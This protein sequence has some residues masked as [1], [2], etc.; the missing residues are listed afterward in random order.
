M[1]AGTAYRL[2]FAAGTLL[3]LLLLQRVLARLLGGR[4]AERNPAGTMFEAGETLGLFLIAG[5][6]VATCVHEESAGE[7]AARVLAFG[8]SGALLLALAGRLGARVLVRARLEAE[9]AAG[10]TAAGI[11]AGAHAAATG[12]IVAGCVVGDDLGS[13]GISLLFFLVA[14]ATLHGLVLL[15]RW[16]T[17]YDDAEEILDRNTAAAFS[18]AGVTVALGLIVSHAV[19]GEFLGLWASLRAYG[20]ALLAGVFLWPV[21]Q[22]VVQGLILGGR[23]ALRGG[24]LDK[25]IGE[26]RDAG[27]GALEAATYI[28]TALLVSTVA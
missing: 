12:I 13:I 5:S 7:D 24:R 19:E 11:A 15:F 3:L 4:G 1:D 21:R 10:N 27:L 22:L 17:T 26:Q 14:Q 16:L 6:V 18:Y 8:G 25:A 2:G 20:V 23:P 28:G 9:I